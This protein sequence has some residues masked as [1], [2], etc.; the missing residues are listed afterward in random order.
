MAIDFLLVGEF[1]PFFRQLFKF[2]FEIWICGLIRPGFA[3]G[4]S[5]MT[6]VSLRH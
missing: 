6:F 1:V 5:C 4:S 3:L 2:T